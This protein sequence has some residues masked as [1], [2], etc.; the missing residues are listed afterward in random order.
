MGYDGTCQMCKQA[1]SNKYGLHR[2]AVFPENCT[3]QSCLLE[4]PLQEPQVLWPESG[5]C[6]PPNRPLT[7]R[8][9]HLTVCSFLGFFQAPSLRGLG[10]ADPARCDPFCYGMQH[11]YREGQ[12]G[13][14]SAMPALVMPR[15]VICQSYCAM[16]SWGMCLSVGFVVVGILPWLTKML[17]FR[18]PW[19]EHAC[20]Q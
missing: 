12:W 14:D 7:S 9:W 18:M 6:Q 8:P 17:C 2:L 15:S 11:A 19:N 10:I 16:C 1:W 4:H 20:P 3:I 13:A 5:A